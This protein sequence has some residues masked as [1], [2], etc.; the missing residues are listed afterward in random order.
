MYLN[1]IE[2]AKALEERLLQH[3]GENLVSFT[4]ILTR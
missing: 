2:A 4:R 3:K 1:R